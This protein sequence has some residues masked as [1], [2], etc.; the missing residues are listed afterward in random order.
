ME[1]CLC[2]VALVVSIAP[3]ATAKNVR[4]YV[5]AAAERTDTFQL[6]PRALADSVNDIRYRVHVHITTIDG[7][8]ADLTGSPPISGNRARAI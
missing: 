3:T 4:V 8:S 1:T 2:A 6:V 7:H 5:Y